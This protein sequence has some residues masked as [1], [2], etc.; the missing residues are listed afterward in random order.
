MKLWKSASE[1]LMDTK[2]HPLDD[3]RERRSFLKKSGFAFWRTHD[4]ADYWL[5]Q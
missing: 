1:W 2:G 3:L 4:C 5:R